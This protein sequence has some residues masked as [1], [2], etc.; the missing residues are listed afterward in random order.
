MYTTKNYKRREKTEERKATVLNIDQDKIAKR[1]N[2]LIL[3][4]INKRTSLAF[5]SRRNRVS[6]AVLQEL[7][8]AFARKE[9]IGTPPRA[10]MT[11]NSSSPP[12]QSQ[13][14]RVE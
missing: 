5:S 7:R 4:L 6:N 8:K 9:I 2:S 3:Y 10:N 12:A 1:K 11:P 13:P 14:G